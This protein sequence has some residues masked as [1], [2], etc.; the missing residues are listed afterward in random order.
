MLF[1]LKLTQAIM[2]AFFGAL[3]CE[4]ASVGYLMNKLQGAQQDIAESERV[5]AV[6]S[7]LTILSNIMQDTS[8]SAMK[9]I[10]APEQH[11]VDFMD[12]FN[13]VHDE[14]REL[15][16][17]AHG[18]ELDEINKL[19]AMLET[20]P[21]VLEQAINLYGVDDAGHKRRLVELASLS[22]RATSQV[23]E[24]LL[25][26][27]ENEKT[28]LAKQAQSLQETKDAL[29]MGLVLSTVLLSSLVTWIVVHLRYRLNVLTDNAVRF[30]AGKQLNAELPGKDE[31]STVD[32][33]FHHMAETVEESKRREKAVIEN[34]LDVI[35]SIDAEGKFV[36]VSPACYSVWGYDP[37]ELVGQRYVEIVEPVGS[38]QSTREFPDITK[39]RS[40]SSYENRIIRKDGTVVDML[41]SSRWSNR[42]KSWFC[43]AHDITDRKRAEQVKRDFVAMISHDLRTPLTSVELSL[44]LLSCGACGDLSEKASTNVS[45]AE[46]NLSFVMT[47]INGL[48]DVEKMDAG[49]LEMRFTSINI[50]DVV[51]RS[52]EAVKPLTIRDGV[53][54]I[55]QSPDIDLTGDE[56]RLVQVL[57]N[58]LSNALKFSPKQAEIRVTVSEV[59]ELVQVSVTDQGPGI[60]KDQQKRIFDRFERVEKTSRQVEGTGLGL[61]ISKAIVEQ[62]GGV[63]GVT[64]EENKGS[65]FFFRIPKEPVNSPASRS[66]RR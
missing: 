3:I 32:R 35:C 64:S 42:E 56:N 1:N 25:T 11:S 8:M 9:M 44:N 57:V 45:D 52:V 7:H 30:A 36:D 49:K 63:I 24:I 60:A 6:V 66:G 18:S 62:H 53:K 27:R 5:S 43:V 21:G 33:A 14:I 37:D 15:R 51:G 23:N 2:L 38:N 61:A 50:A 40:Q 4:L 59:N 39:E 31:I 20:A 48:L 16:T 13:H 19:D 47:L 46:N 54:L 65:T 10:I 28:Q 17:L 41:W 12:I 34:A 55:A 22:N 26:A 29:L 58:L